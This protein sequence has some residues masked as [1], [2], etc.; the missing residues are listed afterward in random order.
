MSKKVK[1]DTKTDRNK[2]GAETPVSLWAR[3]LPRF[4]RFIENKADAERD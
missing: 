2:S 3:R 1:K 4:G